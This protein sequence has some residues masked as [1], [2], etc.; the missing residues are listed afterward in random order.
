MGK[1]KSKIIFDEEKSR[2]KRAIRI[3]HAR[4]TETFK[5]KKK[6]TRKKKHK[7]RIDDDG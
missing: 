3:P 5:D 4:P 2:Q 6:Y 7:G 1:H